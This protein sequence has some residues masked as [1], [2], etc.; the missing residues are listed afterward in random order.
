M[1]RIVIVELTTLPP[2]M[3]GL[4]RQRGILNISQPY[5]PPRPV[6]GIDFT[7]VYTDGVPVR[8][9][10]TE[11]LPANSKLFHKA[12]NMAIGIY[13]ADHVA[14]SIRKKLALTSLTSGG[15]SVGIVGLRTEATTGSN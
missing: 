12:E 11:M 5:R 7:L 1:S 6:M 4:S 13:H 2:S 8:T 3:N 15:C 9:G 10:S 14:P